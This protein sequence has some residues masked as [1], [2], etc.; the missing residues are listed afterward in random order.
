MTAGG[1]VTVEDVAER[2]PD[3]HADRAHPVITTARTA[4]PK[5]MDEYPPQGGSLSAGVGIAVGRFSGRAGGPGARSVPAVA[6]QGEVGC[7]IAFVE[8]LF[9]ILSFQRA[10]R[11]L[12]GPR[13]R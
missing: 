5:I 6:G 3:A 9:A 4:R 7:G 2:S 13:Q 12:L 11:V 8:H 10:F 1:V